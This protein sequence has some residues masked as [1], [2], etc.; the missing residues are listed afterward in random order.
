MSEVSKAKYKTRNYFS[1]KPTYNKRSSVEINQRGFL[2]S[3]NFREKDC[4]R[5]SYNLL[6]HYADKLYSNVS[7]MSSSSTGA[8]NQEDGEDIE[9]SLSKEISTLKEESNSKNR[10]FQ[11]V[12][13]GAKNFLF[14]KTTLD[15]PV[16]LAHAILKD[17]H[18]TKTQQTRFL[19]RLVPVEIT[20]K[21]YLPDVEK[22]FDSI[23]EKYFK[24]T[25]R[26]FSIVYNHRN[27]NS[28]SKDAVIKSIADKVGAL[29]DDHKVDLKAAEISI[30]VEVIKAYVFIG[31]VPDYFKYK[32]Y[33]LLSLC[34]QQDDNKEKV[35]CDNK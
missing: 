28:L 3:C 23:S 4:V 33:N 31:V 35:E 7:D 18:E 11:V 9:A 17:V 5:E 13:S 34:E 6:N 10:R 2:C 27:N 30:I 22:A 20:C 29:R 16:E 14:I 19:L 12:E 24:N 21:A 15:D 26:T 32:K 25:A 8:E 1:K